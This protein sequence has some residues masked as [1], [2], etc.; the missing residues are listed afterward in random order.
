MSD[1]PL[2]Q[3]PQDTLKTSFK[4]VFTKKT[5]IMT[6][7]ELIDAMYVCR[8]LESVAKARGKLLYEVLQANMKTELESLTREVPTM[9]V[10]GAQYPG[11]VASR[12]WQKRLDTEAITAEMGA[13][14]IEEH[15]K[16]ID[17]YQFKSV[18]ESE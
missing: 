11:F 4:D 15:Q 12:I 7:A 14:W 2:A 9:T 13:D 1:T 5:G 17:F 18:K 10:A 8:K 3:S 6:R 16:E